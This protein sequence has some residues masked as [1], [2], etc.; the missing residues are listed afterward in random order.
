MRSFLMWV[1]LSR[2]K[3]DTAVNSLLNKSVSLEK[4][5]QI[6]MTMDIA[7]KFERCFIYSRSNA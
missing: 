4:N 7:D 1:M 6:Q 2:K 3:W 5:Q